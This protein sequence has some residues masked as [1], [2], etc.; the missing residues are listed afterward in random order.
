MGHSINS[1]PRHTAE[2]QKVVALSSNCEKT[3]SIVTV[4]T[5]CCQQKGA[6]AFC[7]NID[8]NPKLLKLCNNTRK[9][10]HEGH[11]PKVDFKK[12]ERGTP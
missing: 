10:F 1:I 4:T 3:N 12:Q 5:S 7:P 2:W 6:D 11:V 8:R 9:S